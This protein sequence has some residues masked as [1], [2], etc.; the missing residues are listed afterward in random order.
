MTTTESLPRW[1]MSVV[2]PSLESP[3]FVQAF[4][5]CVQNITQLSQLFDEQHVHR[6][7]TITIDD[8]LV[9]TFERVVQR[10]NAVH[11]QVRTITVYISCFVHTNSHDYLAQAKMSELE[12]H[13]VVLS[14]LGTRLTAWIGSL[15]VEVLIERSTIASDHAFVLRRMKERATHL[16]TPVE[17]VLA[18]E[19][20]VTGGSAWSKLHG[21][22]TSQLTVE[23]EVAGQSSTLPMS[24][25]RNLAYD[26]DRD[27]RRRAYEAE[28]LGWQRVAV[29]L[30]AAINSIKGEI[31][32]LTRHCKWSSPLDALALCQY[33]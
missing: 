15:D 26:A 17:D 6:H 16:M 30:A 11:E 24:T 8:A 13:T 12:K 18:S 31:N 22:I 7:E 19:L 21:N 10:Y 2:Y 9:Q 20:N 23:L 27:L 3:E 5:E 32:V 14:Q 4:D 1:D 33:Y 28:L 25:I 29:P